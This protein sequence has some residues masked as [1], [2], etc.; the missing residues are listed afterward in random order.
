MSQE[1]Y[2]IR[3]FQPVY[4]LRDRSL[5]CFPMLIPDDF[6]KL[7]SVKGWAL[8]YTGSRP[9]LTTIA[10]DLVGRMADQGRTGF[11]IQGYMAEEG[12]HFIRACEYEELMGHS[13]FQLSRL[14]DRDIGR[15]C[16]RVGIKP[17]ASASRR[18]L[19]R[20]LPKALDEHQEFF[21]NVKGIQLAI[22]MPMTEDV[23]FSDRYFAKPTASLKLCLVRQGTN[24][25]FMTEREWPYR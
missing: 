4:M 17:G 24:I 6:K 25:E 9:A 15:F 12:K 19:V 8:Y 10:A 20:G 21:A 13:V 3:L 5:K 2:R 16:E 7:A 23:A 18:D 1:N 11:V 14:A 22:N